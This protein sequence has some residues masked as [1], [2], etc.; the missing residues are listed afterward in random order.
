MCRSTG[1]LPGL[2]TARVNVHSETENCISGQ[3]HS[4][5]H[6]FVATW[7]DEASWC[8]WT[9]ILSDTL[10]C[11][12]PLLFCS[13][14]LCRPGAGDDR[15]VRLHHGL[16]HRVHLH[17]WD[18]PHGAQERRHGNVFV[19]RPNRQHHSPICHL[20]R[21]VCIYL[22]IPVHVCFHEML[23]CLYL[24]MYLLSW[25]F[26]G[27]Y[28]KVLPYIVMGSLTIASCVVNFFLPETLNRDLPETVAQMQEYHG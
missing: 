16:Q 26:L 23:W 19:R 24:R 22:V 11:L 2:C 25:P 20:F 5:C 28:N 4:L 10:T 15:E 21:Q 3:S 17:G 6:G 27:T 8:E 14:S 9:I 13:A 18:L 7:C 12:R 1:C